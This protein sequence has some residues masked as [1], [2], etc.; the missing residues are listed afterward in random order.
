MRLSKRKLKRII[1]EEVKRITEQ[2]MIQDALKYLEKE[3]NRFLKF[4]ARKG[5]VEVY[6]EYDEVDVFQDTLEY[7]VMLNVRERRRGDGVTVEIGSEIA[8]NK[9]RLSTELVSFRNPEDIYGSEKI[10]DAIIKHSNIIAEYT[11]F[12][13]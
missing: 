6:R 9:R 10:M 5:R 11:E 12:Y 3:A 7:P 4:E 13:P 2:D 1:R 8:A